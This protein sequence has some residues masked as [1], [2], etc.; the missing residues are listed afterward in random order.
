[1]L[2]QGICGTSLQALCFY[3]RCRLHQIPVA[4]G[5]VKQNRR[6]SK[7][8]GNKRKQMEEE[9]EEEE[10]KKEEEEEEMQQICASV[11]FVKFCKA[12]L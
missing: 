10:Q 8:R 5:K 3:T 9:E 4:F 12:H 1:M 7:I 2:H 6:R 11:V